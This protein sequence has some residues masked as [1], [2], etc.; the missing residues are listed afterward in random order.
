MKR[1]IELDDVHL[2]CDYLVEYYHLPDSEAVVAWIKSASDS[3]LEYALSEAVRRKKKRKKLMLEDGEY[4][5]AY[6]T[7]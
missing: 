7:A 1:K 3:E 5:Y 4:E 6:L 2:L